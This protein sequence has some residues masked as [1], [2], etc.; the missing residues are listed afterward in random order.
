LGRG[1]DT[2]S[3]DEI[4]AKLEAQSTLAEISEWSRGD[5]RTWAMESF[6]LAKR[7]VYAFSDRPTCDE[8]RSVALSAAYG[9]AAERDAAA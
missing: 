4:A 1:C 2:Q 6:Q 7:D 3:F 5:A 8:H 9:A